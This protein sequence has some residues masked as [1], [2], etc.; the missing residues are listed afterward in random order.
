MEIIKTVDLKKSF[1]N[2]TV[3][4]E[5][6]KGINISINKGD[7][8][9]IVGPSGSGKTTLLYCLSS[10]ETITAGNVFF[11]GKDI[12]KYSEI[13]LANL[14][15]YSLG[16]VFQFYNLIPN[17]TVYENVLLPKIIANKKEDNIESILETVG[18][19]N[20]KDYYPN[21]LSGGMQQRVAIA[22]ALVNEPTIIFADEPTGN[23][24]QKNGLEIM[25][26]LK[27]LNKEKDITVIL[28][29]H[30]ED[31]LEF[32]NKKIHLIDGRTS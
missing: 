5:V 28:V 17:L 4:T 16:F 20:Y 14:R 29:T 9:G 18:M 30:N 10:L 19:L 7:F 8:T 12:S 13:E 26:I 6:L 2:Q 24:D 22:R 23:L 11:M 21:Q 15:K 1:T 3:K 32:C 27:K 31:Y 25:K